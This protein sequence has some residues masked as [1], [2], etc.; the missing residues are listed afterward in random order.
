MKLFLLAGLGLRHCDAQGEHQV[1]VKVPVPDDPL[2]VLDKW[3]SFAWLP[4]SS[5]SLIYAFAVCDLGTIVDACRHTLLQ[6]IPSITGPSAAIPAASRNFRH[7]FGLQWSPD[8]RALS[9]Q[10]AKEPDNNAGPS[11]CQVMHWIA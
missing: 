3:V 5:S 8:G 7:I 9:M 1:Q 6:R 4:A 10:I 11:I 2:P